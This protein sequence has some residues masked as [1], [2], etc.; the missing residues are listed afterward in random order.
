MDAGDLKPPLEGRIYGEI[1]G[2]VSIL[3]IVIGLIGVMVGLTG[4]SIF[5]YSIAVKDIL[6]GCSEDVLWTKDSLIHSEPHG[7]WFLSGISGDSIAMIG[8]AV[9]IYGGIAGIVCMVVSMLLNREVLLYK[10]GMYFLL[11]LIILSI[12][13]FCAWESEFKISV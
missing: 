11:A 4:N 5:D 10:R 1:A 13:V 12:M 8:I 3:G 6:K 7:Y 9:M 2:W